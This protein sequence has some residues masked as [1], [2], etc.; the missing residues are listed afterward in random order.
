MFDKGN[1]WVL[2]RLS[3]PVSIDIHT[4]GPRVWILTGLGQGT[5]T[6][7]RP[8]DKGTDFNRSNI[9]DIFC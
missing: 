6:G 5:G 8:V 9:M 3:I 7:T 4:Q 2:L 1:P